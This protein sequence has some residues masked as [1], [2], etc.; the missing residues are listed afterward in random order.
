MS[1][2]MSKIAVLAAVL[3]LAACSADS[4]PAPGTSGNP[5]P[6]GS[7]S[8]SSSAT[9]SSS[10]GPAALSVFAA[11]PAPNTFTFDTAGV[12][13]MRTGAVLITYQNLGTMA[14]ELRVVR[15]RDGNF[16]AYRAAMM[17]SVADAASLA[18][19]V[20]KSPSIDP[21]KSSTFG[22]ELSSGTYALACLLTAPDGKA[23]AQHGMIRELTV[24][25]G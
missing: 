14:H 16:S 19:E 18:D 2:L 15:V 7:S 11:E 25:P 23:F 20:A 6:S 22:A 10:G 21:G 13:V 24:T 5:V 9:E 17:T 12:D 1:K 4:K 8:S 3:A